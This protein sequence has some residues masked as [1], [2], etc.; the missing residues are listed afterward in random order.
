MIL[1]CKQD[2]VITSHGATE[3]GENLLT[4]GKAHYESGL[5]STAKPH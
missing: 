5:V 1:D 3:I 4:I 2:D